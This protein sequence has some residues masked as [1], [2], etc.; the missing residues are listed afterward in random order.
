MGYIKEIRALVGKRPVMIVGASVIVHRD[1]KVLLQKRA[2]NGQWGYHGGCME[3]GE[4]PEESAM[5]ELKEETGLIARELKLFGVFAGEK[6]HHVYPNGDEVYITDI[7]YTCGDFENSGDVHDEEVLEL[8][9]FPVH[10][11]PDS[12]TRTTA[13]ILAKFTSEYGGLSS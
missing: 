9:W 1:G 8:K 11:L 6:R 13:D 4:T 12:L 2:D 7:V 10:E 3:L 5:R